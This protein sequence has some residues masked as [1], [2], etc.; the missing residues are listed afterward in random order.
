MFYC[1]GMRRET[2]DEECAGEGEEHKHNSRVSQGACGQQSG[3][4]GEDVT[5]QS[6]SAAIVPTTGAEDY[7][8]P[9][10]CACV[11]VGGC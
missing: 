11:C 2:D 9:C 7:R 3:R 4:S 10:E 8:C 5:D 1:G 6:S